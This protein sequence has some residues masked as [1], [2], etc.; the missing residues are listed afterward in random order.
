MALWWLK[1]NETYL[2]FCWRD[3]TKM[4]VGQTLK[5]YDI[6]AHLSPRLVTPTSWHHASPARGSALEASLNSQHAWDAVKYTVTHTQSM[7]DVGGSGKRPAENVRYTES[8]TPPPPASRAKCHSFRNTSVFRFETCSEN[9]SLKSSSPG[10]SLL[11]LQQPATTARY[12]ADIICGLLTRENRTTVYQK[13]DSKEAQRSL[14]FSREEH[15]VCVRTPPRFLKETVTPLPS[16]VHI[17]L[18]IISNY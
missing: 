10:T 5:L 2:F 7:M 17:I 15:P 14:L 16:N 1:H 4:L 12:H 18:T 3:L 8:K 9:N 11:W 6:S 13:H